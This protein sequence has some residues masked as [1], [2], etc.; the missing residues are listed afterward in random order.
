MFQFLPHVSAL[1]PAIIRYFV[2]NGLRK[3]NNTIVNQHVKAKI[4]SYF[5][6]SIIQIKKPGFRRFLMEIS[7]N[8]VNSLIHLLVF[9]LREAGLAGTRAQS[10]D[11]YGSG[12]WHTASWASSWG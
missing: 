12:L 3:M 9:S 6:R 11:R 2:Y 4:K 8:C 7:G 10:C 5:S 1:F